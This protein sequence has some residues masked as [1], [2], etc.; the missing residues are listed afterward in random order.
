MCSATTLKKCVIN[1]PLDKK[2]KEMRWL[3][4]VEDGDYLV[5]AEGGLMDGVSSPSRSNGSMKFQPTRLPQT[6]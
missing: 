3:K 6:V 4:N 1:T 5:D 2:R